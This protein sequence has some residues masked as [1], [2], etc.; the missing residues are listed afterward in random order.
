MLRE[1]IVF[2]AREDVGLALCPLCRE[3]VAQHESGCTVCA[4]HFHRACLAEMRPKGCTTL[5]CAGEVRARIQVR[6]RELGPLPGIYGRVFTREQQADLIRQIARDL[7]RS[8]EFV[9][10]A[11]CSSHAERAASS[12]A[13]ALRR[14]VEPDLGRSEEVEELA[15]AAL[16]SRL[17]SQ[18]DASSSERGRRTRDL[19]R[20]PDFICNAIDRERQEREKRAEEA[21]LEEELGLADRA[22]LAAFFA[23]MIAV[24][25]VVVWSVVAMGF[26]VYESIPKLFVLYGS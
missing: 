22:I 4:A 16:G 14:P 7:D 12:S 15:P 24:A 23:F 11:L 5:G 9:H 10:D 1:E 25:G 3:P 6:A 19:G 13:A 20:S 8:E 17:G 26:V 2:S 21:D 18:R